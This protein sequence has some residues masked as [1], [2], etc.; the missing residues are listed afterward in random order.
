MH[1][2]EVVKEVLTSNE[3]ESQAG[4]RNEN[5]MFFLWL[6]RENIPSPRSWKAC[7]KK[8]QGVTNVTVRRRKKL[9]GSTA[10]VVGLFFNDKIAGAFCDG[11]PNRR[12]SSQNLHLWRYG[13]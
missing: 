5:T 8:L 4:T 6:I 1:T 12:A 7:R 3:H 13:C 9:A 11:Y 2:Q 10:R